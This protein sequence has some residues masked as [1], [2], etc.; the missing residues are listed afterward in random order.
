MPTFRKSS[1]RDLDVFSFGSYL[2]EMDRKGF[3]YN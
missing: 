3:A 2:N 1:L